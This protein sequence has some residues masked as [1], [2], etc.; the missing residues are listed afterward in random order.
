MAQ[1]A[2]S[3]LIPGAPAQGMP[4][5]SWG[6]TADELFALIVRTRGGDMLAL[7]ELVKRTIGEVRNRARAIVRNDFDAD[8]V[9]SAVY[10]AV[11]RRAATYDPAR[12]SV[13]AWL[14]VM[15]R[16]RALDVLR[17]GKRHAS[18]KFTQDC[19]DVVCAAETSFDSKKHI[20]S[21]PRR[22]TSLSSVRREVI[23]LAFFRG[24]SHIQ[25]A[26]TLD[27]PL[28]TVKSHLRRA[29]IELRRTLTAEV[30]GFPMG[31]HRPK[32][33]VCR[34][35]S[36]RRPAAIIRSNTPRTSTFAQVATFKAIPRPSYG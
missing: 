5:E 19:D 13:R 29:L 33:T 22:L 32:P 8:D 34:V 17:N 16:S 27:M 1:Y 26:T 23:V 4:E 2:A 35:G 6:I 18:S 7:S 3:T 14:M 31:S 11:L 21:I 10:E 36:H 15:C 30:E 12:G 25:I 20:A 9:V 28:G 24:W